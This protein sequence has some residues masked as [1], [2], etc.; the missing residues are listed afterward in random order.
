MEISK[1]KIGDWIYLYESHIINNDTPFLDYKF[2]QI[3][4]ETKAYWILNNGCEKARK[5]DLKKYGDF[6]SWRRFKIM[7]DNSYKMKKLR[8]EYLSSR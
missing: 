8:E 3:T 1:L 7:D 4:G 2:F 5:S 6:Y